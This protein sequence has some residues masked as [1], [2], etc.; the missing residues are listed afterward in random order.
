MTVDFQ[1]YTPT[2]VVFGKDTE[3]RSG[4]LVKE[5]GGKKVL[6]HYG[7][8]SAKKSGLLGRVTASLQKE[9]ISYVELGGVVPNPRLSLVHTGIELCKKEKV[10]FL[11]AVGGGSVIDSA[12][13]IGYGL[14][15]DGEVWDFY[16]KK[17]EIKGCYPIGAVL[18]I[19]ATGSEMS[20]SSVITNEEGNLKRGANSDYCRC[21]FAVL[22]PML[23]YT[24]PQ[25]QT[26]CGVTDI[27]MHT[28]ER[29]FVKKSSMQLTDEIACALLR[30]VKANAYILKENPENYDARANIMWASSL[31]HNGL[32]G[33]GNS[34][35]G[36]WALHQM[37]HEIGGL[38]DVAH[39]AGL[40]A[41]WNSWARYVYKDN[42]ERFA[43]L[44]RNLFGLA[45]TGNPDADALATIEAMHAFYKDI[46]MPTSF[47]ELKIDPTPAQIEEMAIK[48]TFFGKR[49]IG[50]FKVLGRDDIMA[51][52]T[53]A[54]K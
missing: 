21:K 6:V 38:F 24:L 34:S 11:L 12:K 52:Y 42:P 54:A 13:A 53:V 23:T 1:Q 35:R 44:G 41:L 8:S 4:S 31:S 7:L 9:G 2:K 26:M 10:D 45:P 15:H 32:T 27:M 43:L 17:R 51:I 28:L 48:C 49:T 36:D 16:S 46:N 22:D 39:A 50:D 19:A 40:A 20:D 18:T 47:A 37:E 5:F 14:F 33:A 30:T 29:Y 3:D 25:Y